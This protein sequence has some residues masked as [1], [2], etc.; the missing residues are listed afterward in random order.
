MLIVLPFPDV[1]N[2]IFLLALQ[3]KVIS[4]LLV[5]SVLSTIAAH[6]LR[7]EVIFVKVNHEVTPVIAEEAMEVA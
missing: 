2:L 5:V 7:G 1:G 4:R 6:V 3:I